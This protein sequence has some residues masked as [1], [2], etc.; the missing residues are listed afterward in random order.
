VREAVRI[1]DVQ[2][3]ASVMAR[4]IVNKGL[5]RLLALAVPG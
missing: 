4:V 1:V 3:L 2:R 5:A